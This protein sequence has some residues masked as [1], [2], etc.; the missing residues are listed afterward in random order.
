MTNSYLVTRIMIWALTAVG[1]LVAAGSIVLPVYIRSR[2]A[3]P[4]TPADVQFVIS[5][6]GPSL[7]AGLLLIIV[8]LVARAIVNAAQHAAEIAA[9]LKTAHTA[10]QASSGVVPGP[11]PQ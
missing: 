2:V 8:G 1:A 9:I 6:F 11:A 3:T 7:A 10:P 4:M 5:T